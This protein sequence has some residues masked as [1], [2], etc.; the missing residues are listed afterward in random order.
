M[1]FFLWLA[2]STLIIAPDYLAFFNLLA[3]GPSGGYRYL[4]DSNLDWG[5]D[6][7][8]MARYVQEQGIDRVVRSVLSWE[9]CESAARKLD[10]SALMA[11]LTARE[12]AKA[13]DI[14]RAAV[15]SAQKSFDEMYNA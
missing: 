13:E 11:A 9:A 2:V 4:V 5:H 8:G 15:V 3:G 14:M 7:P 1:A 10:T 6:L 12:T